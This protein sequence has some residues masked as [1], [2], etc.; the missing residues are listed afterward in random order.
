M[1]KYLL[2]LSL[3]FI[4]TNVSAGYYKWSSEFWWWVLNHNDIC[5]PTAQ[6]TTCTVDSWKHY[7]HYTC[8]VDNSYINY[9]TIYQYSKHY[10]LG[11]YDKFGEWNP[12]IHN[13]KKYSR[14]HCKV[15]D[16]SCN[17]IYR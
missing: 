7:Q 11:D 9:T 8:D 16:W 10:T 13:F 6:W 2:I 4:T 5:Y 12:T 3:L 1:K 15:V 14:V 17:C